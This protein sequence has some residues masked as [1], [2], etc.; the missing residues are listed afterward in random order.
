MKI[1]QKNL[2]QGIVKVIVESDDD[3]W[4]LSQVVSAGDVVS[5]KSF[6]KIKVR[7]DADPVKKSVFISIEVEKVEFQPALLRISGKIV[8]APDDVSKGSYHTFNIEIGSSFSIFKS[9]WLSYHLK[10]LE[11]ASKARVGKILICVFDREEAFF[12]LTQVSGFTVLNHLKGSVAKKA[13]DDSVKENFYQ[14]IIKVMKDYDLRYEPSFIILASPAFWREELM[15]VLKDD[16]LKKKIVQSACSCVD[17]KAINEVLKRDEVKAALKDERSRQ[18]IVLMEEV[19]S[20]ISKEANV[21]YGFSAVENAVLCGAVDSL[22][23]SSDLIL[24]KQE[25]GSFSGLNL[26]MEKVDRSKGEV[27]ILS[28]ENDAGKMLDGVGGIAALL[29]FKVI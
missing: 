12:A 4:Y 8:E 23:V 24:K 7:E 11:D 22:L 10:S 29:R 3:L 6:R 21:A 5:G 18:E 1:V 17:E 19:L 26:L 15:S 25:D 14:S 27:H 13:F 16:S 28:S 20:R 9:S 2:K